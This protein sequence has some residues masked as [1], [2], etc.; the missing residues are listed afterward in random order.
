MALYQ[1][2][3]AYDGTDF[4]G[5][6]RQRK[7]RTVQSELENALKNLGWK[8]KSIQAAGRTDTGVHAI[9]QVI[10]F[11]LDWRH[12]DLN[13]QNALNAILPM[14]MAVKSVRKATGEFHPRFDALSRKYRYSIYCDSIRDPLLDRFA[15]QVHPK[16]KLGLLEDAAKQMI[17]THD[18]KCFGRP[19]KEESGTIRTIISAEWKR[20]KIFFQFDVSA[21]AFLYHMVRRMV[22]LQVKVGQGVISAVELLEAVE[23]RSNL[24]PGIAPARGLVLVE[25]KY[26]R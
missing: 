24:I 4:L 15:W 2:K 19:P 6:Q 17:G 7:G 9:G 13:L 1:L 3:L 23:G 20:G 21:N 5:F 12:S 10:A 16:V 14:D 25:V 11:A 8:E 18:F 26:A 22:F